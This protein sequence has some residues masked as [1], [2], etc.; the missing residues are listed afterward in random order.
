MLSFFK[1]VALVHNLSFTGQEILRDTV[2]GLDG[3]KRKLLIVEEKKK[4]F[5]SHIIDLDEV[6]TCKVRKVYTAIDINGYKRN[7]PEEYLRSIALEFEFRTNRSP[8]VANFYRNEN[9]SLYEIKELEARVRNW[10]IMLSKMLQNKTLSSI[11]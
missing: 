3:P 6:H 4:N 10:E 7:R 9:N 5:D 1:K 11:S 2:I 8:V